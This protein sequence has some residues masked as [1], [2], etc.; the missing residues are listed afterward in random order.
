LLW[1]INEAPKENKSRGGEGT[2]RRAKGDVPQF[3]SFRR[4]MD[5]LRLKK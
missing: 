5:K 3:D 1:K 4:H 2:E